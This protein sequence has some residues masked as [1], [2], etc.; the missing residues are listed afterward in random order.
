MSILDNGDW[1]TLAE[2]CGNDLL[3]MIAMTVF[4]IITME[5]KVPALAAFRWWN[6]VETLTVRH[7]APELERKL[8]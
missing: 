3:R 2:Y 4:I 5:F 1:L 7:I 8:L 6:E